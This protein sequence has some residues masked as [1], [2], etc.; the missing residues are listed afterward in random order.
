M[1]DA[2]R[3]T[4]EGTGCSCVR[5]LL[6]CNFS[7]CTLRQ[8]NGQDKFSAHPS[9]RAEHV[10]NFGAGNFSLK[11]LDSF[12]QCARNDLHLNIARITCAEWSD[13]RDGVRLPA[14]G[15][16]KAQASLN[17]NSRRR[18]PTPRF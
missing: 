15:N 9:Q 11:G 2:Y 17:N 1:T 6:R 16:E 8:E 12:L 18:G 4:Q 13:I 10:H 7:F 14:W 3:S 5:F